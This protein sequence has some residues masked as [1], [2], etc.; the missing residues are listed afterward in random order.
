A[1]EHYTYAVAVA[2]YAARTCVVTHRGAL[3]FIGSAARTHKMRVVA[4]DLQRRIPENVPL[5]LFLGLGRV[6][7]EVLQ[8][9]EFGR[10]D[11]AAAGGHLKIWFK[12]IA[13]HN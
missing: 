9:I 2:F 11:A 4:R 5:V 1:I 13:Q 12:I 10:R 3:H 6:V 8:N 7:V